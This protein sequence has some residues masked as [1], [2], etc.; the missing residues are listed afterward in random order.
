MLRSVRGG[1][2]PSGRSALEPSESEGDGHSG[3][4]VLTLLL[5]IKGQLE[6]NN[7]VWNSSDKKKVSYAESS[8]IEG[9]NDITQGLC[10]AGIFSRGGPPNGVEDQEEQKR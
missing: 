7:L 6:A 9:K 5:R 4:L 1:F 10:F 3:D 8:H 2:E